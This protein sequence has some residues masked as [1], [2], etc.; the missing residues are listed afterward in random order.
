MLRSRIST[1]DSALDQSVL[2]RLH[3]STLSMSRSIPVPPP[4]RNK[5]YAMSC[6]RRAHLMG[7]YPQVAF[8]FARY[9]APW[10]DVVAPMDTLRMLLW[11]THYRD[12]LPS[13]QD[14]QR[15]ETEAQA[16]LDVLQMVVAEHPTQENCGMM[17]FAL[18]EHLRA[19]RVLRAVT[20]ARFCGVVR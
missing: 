19:L 15:E 7:A 3:D 11:H 18:N 6:G 14:A 4:A 2:D 13:L 16:R 1:E 10:S 17:Q 5:Y 8:D 9:H 12:N 20:E